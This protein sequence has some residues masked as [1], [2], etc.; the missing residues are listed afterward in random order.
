MRQINLED[1]VTGCDHFT[2]KEALYLPTWGRCAN[3]ADGLSDE[4]LD[5][6][7]KVFQKMDQ[8]RLFFGSSIRVHVA[9]RPE[10][11]NAEIGG[12]KNS[13][14]KYGMA[15]DFDVVSLDCDDA[16]QKILDANMLESWET[17]MED[18][19]PGS[20]WVHLDTRDVPPGGH[21]YFKP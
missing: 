2:W 21:R 7:E 19:P 17:R 5:N 12:A 13:A 9:Y 15:V 6:L 14:H 3:E 1:K 11:Y 8:V 20:P 18:N 10:K 16:R 4:I